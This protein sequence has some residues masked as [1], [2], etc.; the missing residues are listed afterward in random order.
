M[1]ELQRLGHEAIAIDVTGH[2]E[3]GDEG[4]TVDGR[5][6]SVLSVL[7]HGDMLVGHSGGGFEITRAAAETFTTPVSVPRFWRGELPRSPLNPG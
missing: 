1:P 6:D 3:R 7:D 4:A 2:G 5:L